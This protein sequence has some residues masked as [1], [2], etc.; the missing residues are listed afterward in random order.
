M[1]I[2]FAQVRITAGVFRLSYTDML[3]PD[4]MGKPLVKNSGK[5]IRTGY[6]I[7]VTWLE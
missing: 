1:R 5:F 3:Y 2:H 7:Y 6:Q 4:G